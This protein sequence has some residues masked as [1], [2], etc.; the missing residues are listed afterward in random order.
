[1][2]S[3]SNRAATIVRAAGAADG[4]NVARDFGS[5]PVGTV[6]EPSVPV[7]SGSVD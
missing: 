3:G 7:T 5:H 4:S 2:S 1:V 6:P